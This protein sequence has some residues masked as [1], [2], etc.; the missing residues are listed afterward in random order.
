MKKIIF[1]AIA[2]MGFVFMNAQENIIKVNPL[3]FLGGTDLLSFEHKFGA[4]TSGSVGL[5]FASYKLGGYKYKDNGAEL[6]FRY[7][8]KEAMEGLYGGVR[9]GFSS[10]KNTYDSAGFFGPSSGNSSL[11]TKF[12]T[13]KAGVKGGYQWIWDSGLSLDLNLGLGYTK[14]TYK[15]DSTVDAEDIAF[16]NF[17]GSSVGPNFGFALGYAF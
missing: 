8:V 4:H 13:I 3:A 1:T 17:K 16:F 2:V 9:V 12:T 11:D 15:Y 6:Q 10:G 7:Y 5:G 14:Y